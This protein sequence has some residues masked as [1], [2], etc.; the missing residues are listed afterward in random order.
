MTHRLE[1][2]LAKIEGAQKPTDDNWPWVCVSVGHSETEDE[3]MARAYPD[4]KPEK[5]NFILRKMVKALDGR[6]APGYVPANSESPNYGL[7]E[8]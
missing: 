6:V 4:G 8:G 7:R 2:R 1:S 5:T 3:A